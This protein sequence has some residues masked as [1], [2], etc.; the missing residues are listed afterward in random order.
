MLPSC[1]I[2]SLPPYTP[3][4]EQGVSVSARLVV[5]KKYQLLV[6]QYTHFC[7][8]RNLFRRVHDGIYS[9]VNYSSSR[10]YVYVPLFYGFLRWDN[11]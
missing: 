9:V 3:A 6:L 1:L 5:G 8:R 11:F 7:S 2:A 10:V 4:Y